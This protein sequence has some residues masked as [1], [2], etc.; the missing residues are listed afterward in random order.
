MFEP[1]RGR[2]APGTRCS[3]AGADV[4]RQ[5]KETTQSSRR[6]STRWA[7]PRRRAIRV[8]RDALRLS[9]VVRS[10]PRRRRRRQTLHKRP[11]PNPRHRSWLGARVRRGLGCP[12][13][14]DYDTERDAGPEGG[15]EREHAA[16]ACCRCATTP[17]SR[18]RRASRKC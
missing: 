5:G 4:A 13:R 11:M 17:S 6:R 9:Q 10:A 16:I 7:P 14:P 2:P 8:D 1:R 15:F 18:H 12:R 3:T